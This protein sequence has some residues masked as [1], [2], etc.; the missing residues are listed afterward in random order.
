M[1]RLLLPLLFLFT[2]GSVGCPATVTPSVGSCASVC[3]R[4]IA[5]ACTFV[6]P[7]PTGATC[8]AVCLNLQASG[9]P[10]WNLACRASAPSC[11]AMDLCERGR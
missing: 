11:A 5:L 2:A 9:L 6:R 3:A 1:K 7:T 8:E 4:G 10:A